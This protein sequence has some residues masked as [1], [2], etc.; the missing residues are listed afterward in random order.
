[1]P[2]DPATHEE[3][4]AI[5][6]RHTMLLHTLVEENGGSIE[7]SFERIDSTMGRMIARTPEGKAPFLYVAIEND[8][9]VARTGFI[10]TNLIHEGVTYVGEPDV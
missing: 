3:I 9:I 5:E 10:A 8:K 7:F 2:L 1:M 4:T 6:R